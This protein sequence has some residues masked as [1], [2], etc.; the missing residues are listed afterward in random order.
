V[1]SALLAVP[2]VNQMVQ[3]LVGHVEQTWNTQST[4]QNVA[5]VSTLVPWAVAAGAGIIRMSGSLTI[6]PTNPLHAGFTIVDRGSEVA[7][8]VTVDVLPIVQALE[9]LAHHGGGPSDA[10]GQPGDADTPQ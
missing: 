5:M 9:R 6:P 8:T 1:I 2:Q 7:I 10:A 4:G 3:N